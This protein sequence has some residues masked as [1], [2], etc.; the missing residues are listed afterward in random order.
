MLEFWYYFIDQYW[1]PI[2]L[3]KLWSLRDASY[4]TCILEKKR[5]KKGLVLLW[6]LHNADLKWGRHE[7]WNSLHN[8]PEFFQRVWNSNRENQC[9]NFEWW[10]SRHI[11]W[12]RISVG[13][14]WCCFYFCMLIPVVYLQLACPLQLLF[15]WWHRQFF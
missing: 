9:I 13:C 8:A 1:S 10:W 6:N 15:F 14:C 12:K 7:V 11:V 3:T 4:C 2:I 5:G